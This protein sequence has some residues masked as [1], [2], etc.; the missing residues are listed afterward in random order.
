MD[1][2]V[3]ISQRGRYDEKGKVIQKYELNE[4]KKVML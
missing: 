3:R 4:L 1:Y 2:K